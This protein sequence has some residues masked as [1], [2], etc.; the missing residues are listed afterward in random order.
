M[1]KIKCFII[2]V[3]FLTVTACAVD[4]STAITKIEQPTTVQPLSD[5]NQYLMRYMA[6][7][8]EK[9]D[10]VIEWFWAVNI[11]KQLEDFNKV[12]PLQISDMTTL[13]KTE[14]INRTIIYTF[15][16]SSKPKVDRDAMV[17]QMT[18]AICTDPNV[19]MSLEVM[20]G[21]VVYQY[22]LNNQLYDT[23][24]FTKKSCSS[25]PGPGI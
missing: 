3:L 17:K 2:T 12:L 24:Y 21:T 8:P 19:R 10:E 20:Q 22:Q 18:Y 6:Q 11:K 7:Y 1:K 16:L 13:H 9:A 14:L 25:D 23:I 4:S 15:K 5:R